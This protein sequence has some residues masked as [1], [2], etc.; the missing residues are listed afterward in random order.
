MQDELLVFSNATDLATYYNAL[1]RPWVAMRT[2][3]AWARIDLETLGTPFDELELE[4]LQRLPLFRA[5]PHYSREK[6][7]MNASSGVAII[8]VH[9]V[10]QSPT[11]LGFPGQPLK[12]DA[13]EGAPWPEQQLLMDPSLAYHFHFTNVGRDRGRAKRISDQ[14]Q[15][16]R[17]QAT[18]AA[19]M[20]TTRGKLLAS[21][22]KQVREWRLQHPELQLAKKARDLSAPEGTVCINCG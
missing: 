11:G 9:G 20:N 1:P 6:Y 17:V 21:R 2:W 14:V 16:S 10:Y 18:L 5:P 19:Q 22:V 13:P 12:A 8:N 4:D 3:S 15:D 7:V